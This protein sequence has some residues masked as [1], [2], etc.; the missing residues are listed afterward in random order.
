MSNFAK[1]LTG[2]LLLRNEIPLGNF[3]IDYLLKNNLLQSIQPI[4]N[5]KF[6][7]ECLRCG[8]QKNNLFAE[9]PCAICQKTHLYC[10]K[11]IE[12]GRVMKC[13]PLYEWTGNP[14]VWLK[15][16]NP[17]TWKGKLTEDQQKAAKQIVQTI[18]K[19]GEELLVWAVC[20]A[21]KTEMLFP[22][23]IEA[24]KLGKR[25]CITT[26][27]ADVVR[28][29]KPRI[30]QA[31]AGVSI[32]A[33]YGGSTDK[34]GVGQIIIATTHQLLRFKEAFDMMIIDEIDAFPYH[35]D[36]SLPF[37]TKRAL[38]K[39][40]STIYLTATPREEQHSRIVSKKLPH[41]FVPKR[42]HN[43]PL[44]VPQLKLCLFL[45]HHLNKVIFPTTFL[46]W[47]R[48]RENATRQLLI[49]LPTINL[50][51]KMYQTFKQQTSE[52]RT[53]FVHAEDSKREEKVELFRRME[54]DIL[55]TTTI[56][57]RGVTF[58]AI[59]VAVL[60]AGHDVFDEAALVQIAGRA[61]RSP[62]DPTGEV[63]FFHDGKTEA[64]VKAIESIQLMNK[65]G[66]FK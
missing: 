60:H 36:S 13:E 49:F 41:V 8:N 50:A 26:P 14:P 39:H 65:R 24:L 34:D 4:L 21:G 40:G 25:I 31:F 17:C 64:M 20:G 22:G 53:T 16:E 19:S 43:H 62:Q 38:K 29:L 27:R 5:K 33:L 23:I 51:E 35:H 1:L 42:Y 63:L 6:H 61:G 30:Q 37:A 59:D 58:P 32:E 28:E 45:T 15:H 55:F 54:I 46:T 44:P 56:L 3:M 52:Y 12:M 11:C 57:E 66:G 10:R 9:I 48:N 7:T 47:L 2:K 18:H